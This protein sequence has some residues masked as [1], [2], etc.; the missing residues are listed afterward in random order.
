M[1]KGRNTVAV[2]GLLLLGLGSQAMAQ[3]SPSYGPDASYWNS[4]SYTYNS[5]LNGNN[6]NGTPSYTYTAPFKMTGVLLNNPGTL[7]NDAYNYNTTPYNSGGQ[8]EVFFQSTLAGDIGGTEIYVGQ[9]YGNYPGGSGYYLSSPQTD[10]VGNTVPSWSQELT[11]VSEDA[12]TQTPLQAGDLIEVEANVGTYYGGEFNVNEAHNTDP[13]YNFYIKILQTNYG[14]PAPQIV[15]LSNI[16]TPIS[17]VVTS[18]SQSQNTSTGY[19][20]SQIAKFSYNAAPGS[21]EYLQGDWVELQDVQLVPGTLSGNAW[22]A[23]NYYMVESSSGLELPIMLGSA[24]DFTTAPMGYFNIYGVFNQDADS[25][26][27]DGYLISIPDASDIVAVP[28]PISLS[29]LAGLTTLLLI[30]RRA[31][32]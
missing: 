31:G 1:R 20:Q 22:A 29:M 18:Y 10:S 8:W 5:V 17:T 24:S 4:I 27:E 32:R 28:E 19:P 2:L 23:N 3:L 26:D 30:R 14:I 21:G 6:S 11:R 15:S 9:D 25:S 13:T 7:L 12:D 16:E